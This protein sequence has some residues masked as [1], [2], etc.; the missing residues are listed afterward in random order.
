VIYFYWYLG[1]GAVTLLVMYVSH[2]LNSRQESQG[3]KDILDAM[4][5]EHKKL[6]YKILN[7]YAVP[8]L[9]SIVVILFWPVAFYMKIKDMKD[10]RTGNGFEEK[11]FKVVDDDLLSRKTVEQIESSEMIEDPLGAVPSVAFGHL[12]KRW[13]DLLNHILPNDELW[14]FKTTWEGDW[15]NKDIRYGYV[16]VRNGS[17]QE[18]ILTARIPIENEYL[19]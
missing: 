15:G 7:N 10:K 2:K 6:S 14:S 1:L 3:L 11:V 5:P 12:N 13:M 4:N 16:L 8:A 18:Y 17:L 9:A 19:G